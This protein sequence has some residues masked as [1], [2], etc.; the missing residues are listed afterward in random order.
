MC[1]AR[2]QQVK[3]LMEIISEGPE[4]F[5][6]FLTD[7]KTAGHHLYKPIFQLIYALS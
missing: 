2:E 1:E 6:T 5:Y 7:A 3:K 4:G